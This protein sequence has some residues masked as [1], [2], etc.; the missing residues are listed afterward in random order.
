MGA[1][2]IGGRVVTRPSAR[3][4]PAVITHKKW[5]HIQKTSDRL[6]IDNSRYGLFWCGRSI[7]RSNMAFLR[8]YIHTI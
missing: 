8:S 4:F 2:E 5:D 1:V 6:R 3:L 7:L